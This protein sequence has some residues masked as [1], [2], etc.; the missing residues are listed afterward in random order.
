GLTMIDS[1][2]K[3][4][5]AVPAI[6]WFLVLGGVGFLSGFL[7]PITLN[8][9]ANQGPLLGIFIT[10]PLGAVFGLA[11]YAICRAQRVPA[12][13]QWNLIV[14]ASVALC[15]VTLSLCFPSPELQGYA[16]EAE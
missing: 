8:P 1:Q 11:L 9:E 10:G 3:E 6:V 2:V 16:L 7:G 15:L 13:T 5:R 14:Y 12:K 4:S